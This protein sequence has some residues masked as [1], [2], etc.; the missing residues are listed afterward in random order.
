M[1][2]CQR[3]LAVG[4]VFTMSMFDT[5][6]ICPSCKTIEIAHPLYPKAREAER[7]EVQKGNYNFAGIGCPE[8][9]C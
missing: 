5:D 7:V 8:D 6:M 2:S 1:R 4:S 3:C 9:L